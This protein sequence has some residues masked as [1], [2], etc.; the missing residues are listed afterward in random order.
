MMNEMIYSWISAEF[1][2]GPP[3]YCEAETVVGPC[4]PTEQLADLHAKANVERESRSVSD[5]RTPTSKYTI[6]MFEDAKPMF[7]HIYVRVVGLKYHDKAPPFAKDIQL[8]AENEN[9]HDD[10]A[11]AA[12]ADNVKF[13]YL[14]R[15]DARF[16]R[17]LQN[18]KEVH[19]KR[20]RDTYYDLGLEF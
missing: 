10:Q 17:A 4:F 8:V 3:G 18:V 12:Y 14:T 15:E 5:V 20:R 13:G 2:T 16:Y 6:R 1:L 11:V 19:I 9:P 7:Q